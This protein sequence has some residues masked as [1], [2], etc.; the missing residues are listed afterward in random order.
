MPVQMSPDVAE[1]LARAVAGIGGPVGVT[2]DHRAVPIGSGEWVTY[3]YGLAPAG[4][5]TLR[6]L[7][8]LGLRPGG[9]V[10]V[11]ALARPKGRW[12][13]YLYA[14][15]TARPKRAMT[16]AKWAALA[17]ANRARRICP[18]CG[19]DAGYVIPQRLGEC[20]ECHYGPAETICESDQFGKVA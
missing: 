5:A 18:T 2:L 20:V 11:A 17:R 8:A 4:L 1:A 6:Q 7:S 15:S 3:R 13:A 9:C 16:P 12:V 10:P 14:V 19:A